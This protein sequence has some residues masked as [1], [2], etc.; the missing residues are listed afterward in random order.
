MVLSWLTIFDDKHFPSKGQLFLILELP[1]SLISLFSW[2]MFMLW[3]FVIVLILLLLSVLT[4]MRLFGKWVSN[5]WKKYW[6]VLVVTPFLCGGSDYKTR[7]VGNFVFHFSTC[8]LI[9]QFPYIA[10]IIH[11]IFETNSSFHVK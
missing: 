1:P 8:G 9:N 7:A 3:L 5:N 6:S 10:T 11:K 4:R 2:K